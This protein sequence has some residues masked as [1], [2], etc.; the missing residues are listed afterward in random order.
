MRLPVCGS[1]TTLLRSQ[2]FNLISA[3]NCI[4]MRLFEKHAETQVETHFKHWYAVLFNAVLDYCAA[5]K[6]SI[7]YSPTG[8]QIVKNTTKPITP[9]LFLRI[10]NYPEK[11]YVCHRVRLGPA[12]YWEIPVDA[13]LP[14]LIRL[15]RSELPTGPDNRNRR[16]ICIFHDIE[17]N[18][19]T[20]IS[21][22]AC[23]DNL[24]RMLT[25]E[26]ELGVDATYDVLGSL[27]ERKRSEIWAF[28][29]RHSI[30]FH[31]FN[32]HIE[33]LT[34]LQR[35]REVDLRVRGYRPPRSRITAE[36]ED[37]NLTYF[38]FEWLA[39]SAFSFGFHSCR[40][41][42]GLIKIPIDLD[43]YP[44]FTG[45]V[46]YEDWEQNLLERARESQFFAFGLHDCYA[47]RW[48]TRYPELLV[49]L[50]KI[51]DLVSADALCDRIFLEEN[52]GSHTRNE[53]SQLESDFEFETISRY[54]ALAGL[55][56]FVLY[57]SPPAE[58]VAERS[59]TS[60]GYR[61]SGRPISVT[62]SPKGRPRVQSSVCVFW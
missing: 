57:G 17:E 11:R 10:Y 46:A 48:L 3:N 56:Q 42:N 36:L 44:L 35:C 32:H 23:A 37:Y 51:G 18:V 29:P 34:Q 53:P 1:R 50:R 31:S 20:D 60:T 33:D 45:A 62:T 21:A 15:R 30:A 58:Y 16:Q 7:L 28:N 40:L 6:L 55:K 38:N 19:S 12:E 22:A 52:S 2:Q 61:E 14:H 26:K 41:E 24:A 59:Q 47:E 5:T 43:D 39:S 13:N 25:I 4:G 54:A 8:E 27:F 9:D 49:K